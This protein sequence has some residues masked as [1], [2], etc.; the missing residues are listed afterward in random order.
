MN[1][2]NRGSSHS[3]RTRT[4]IESAANAVFERLEDRQMMSVVTNTNDAGPGSLR[5]AVCG[6]RRPQYA[7]LRER[8]AGSVFARMNRS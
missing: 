5:E 6:A 2:H 1:S 8:T 3:A 4:R 7:P